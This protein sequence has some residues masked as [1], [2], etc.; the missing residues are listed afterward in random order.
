MSEAN[1][2]LIRQIYA[3]RIANDFKTVVAG[4]APEVKFHSGGVSTDFATFGARESQD[5]MLEFFSQV[6]DALKTEYFRLD[7]VFAEA[8]RVFALGRYAFTVKAT[9]RR[10]ESDWI[11]IITVRDGQIV[12]WRE[13]FDTAALV[14]A[15]QV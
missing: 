8:D 9:G 1:K 3:A 14:A 13:H 11:N 10:M 15:N 5:R 12:E 4:C 6:S 2:L 7:E